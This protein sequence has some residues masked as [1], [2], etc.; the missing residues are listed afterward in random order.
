MY[1]G[2]AKTKQLCRWNAL[3][4]GVVGCTK[5]GQDSGQNLDKKTWNNPRQSGQVKIRLGY[6]MR[7]GR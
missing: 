5:Y 2:R 7:V 6:R 3:E 1:R 4:L